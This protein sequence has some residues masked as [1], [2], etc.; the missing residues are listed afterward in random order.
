[1]QVQPPEGVPIDH[2]CP[3]AGRSQLRRVH[4]GEIGEGARATR[5]TKGIGLRRAR[6]EP[7]V[8]EPHAVCRR[9]QVIRQLVLQ[10]RPGR[11]PA[12]RQSSLPIVV[13]PR[14]IVEH[15]R[16]RRLVPT[17]R[18]VAVAAA[19]TRAPCILI[20][21]VKLGCGHAALRHH[22]SIVGEV[23]LGKRDRRGP[24]HVPS[25]NKDA[26]VA[27]AASVLQ[28]RLEQNRAAHAQELR[29]RALTR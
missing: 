15:E 29:R 9:A 5:L 19:Y 4:G 13:S 12:S 8:A 3:R 20:G 16:R 18:R 26:R 22:K 1:M 27:L 25:T 14:S 24:G 7:Q 10:R 6:R 11:Q 2:V 28:L 23:E 21:A 17:C